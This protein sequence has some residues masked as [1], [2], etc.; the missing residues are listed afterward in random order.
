MAALAVILLS[1]ALTLRQWR[2][3]RSSQSGGKPRATRL[4][5]LAEQPPPKETITPTGR[6][7]AGVACIGCVLFGYH[8]GVVNAL[9]S[10]SATCFAVTPWQG[11]VALRPAGAF[12]GSSAV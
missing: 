11:R 3:G 10:D 5:L 8:L 9:L 2:T 12:L 1:Q 6:V 4:Q 7:V